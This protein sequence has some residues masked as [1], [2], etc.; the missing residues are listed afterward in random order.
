MISLYA[1]N[2][3]LQKEAWKKQVREKFRTEIQD[4]LTKQYDFFAM[5]AHPNV[6]AKTY[7]KEHFQ[8]TLGKIYKPF[9]DDN[10]FSLALDKKDAEGNKE[11]LDELKKH[12]FIVEKGVGQ[13][14]KAVMEE[15]IRQEGE[16]YKVPRDK[17][18]VLMVMMED[19]AGKSGKFAPQG[20]IAIGLKYTKD[21]LEIVEHLS[22]L[23]YILFH[24]RK[25]EGQHLYAIKES[26]KVCSAEEMDEGVYRNVTTTD[27]YAV[28]EFEPE[29]LNSAQLH[30]SKR[31]FVERT[32]Y[33]AQFAFFH[34]L[35]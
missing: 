16:M 6:D 1:R 3:S 18:G 5:Q 27:L 10:I 19:F 34:D 21:S 8:Q 33:D 2:N 20:K 26:I 25:D 35:K 30:S 23:G 32:R 29:E 13:D 14:P 15:V 31:S 22:E 24:T 17:Q 11:L 7:L 12:F 9:N 4:M 28:V